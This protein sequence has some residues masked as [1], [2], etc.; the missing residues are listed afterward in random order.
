MGDINIRG[1][2]RKDHHEPDKHNGVITHLDQTPWN[3]KSSG[4]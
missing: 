3:E 4:A 1:V 2:N